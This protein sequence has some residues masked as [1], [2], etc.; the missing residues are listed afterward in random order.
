MGDKSSFSGNKRVQNGL[1]IVFE[2]ID[3]TGKTTQ[4]RMAAEV[5]TAEGWA[6]NTTRSLGGTPVGEALRDVILSPVA[7]PD[8]TDLYI[9]AAIQEALIGAIEAQREQGNVI[10]MDRGP[11]S[12]AAYEIFGSG[13]EAKLG[14][15]HV[16]RG[17]ACLKPELTIFYDVDVDD[18]LKRVRQKPG[19]ADYFESKPS[20]FF[21]HVNR[22]YHEAVKRYPDQVSTVDANRSI[23]AVHDESMQRIR[24]ILAK[25]VTFTPA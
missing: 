20:S 18:A 22:G 1:L 7:R 6:V 5:L 10:L 9:S 23:E 17:M 4:L 14:W 11:L 21:D 8:T 19:Q 2:G 15:Q 12:L 3:G 25:A 16:G 13:L 24:E